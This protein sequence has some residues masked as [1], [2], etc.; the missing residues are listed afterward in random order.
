MGLAGASKP[1]PNREHAVRHVGV[2]NI[3]NDFFPRNGFFAC[4]CFSLS[5][6]LQY[7]ALQKIAIVPLNLQQHGCYPCKKKFS[8]RHL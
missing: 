1:F 3:S 5:H 7:D 6:S 4:S 2:S 8:V